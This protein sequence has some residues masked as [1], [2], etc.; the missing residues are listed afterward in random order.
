MRKALQAI[1]EEQKQ[2]L[3][4]AAQR[5]AASR[6]PSR[7]PSRASSPARSDASDFSCS[8]A[9][10]RDPTSI[11]CRGCNNTRIE[12]VTED[13]AE[14]AKQLLAQASSPACSAASAYD[15]YACDPVGMYGNPNMSDESRRTE[16]MQ[17]TSVPFIYCSMTPMGGLQLPPL[18]PGVYPSVAPTSEHAG[19]PS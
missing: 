17:V 12:E 6:S 1:T 10:G 15:S 3:I 18:I 16:Y 11:S 19:S 14:P 4:S 8:G 5:T 9:W 13:A 2:S 7:R